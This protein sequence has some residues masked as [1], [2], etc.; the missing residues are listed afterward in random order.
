[1]KEISGYDFIKYCRDHGV[2]VSS[3]SVYPHLKALLN[4]KI[5]TFRVEGRKKI[6][7]FTEEGKVYFSREMEKDNESGIVFD[8]LK[9]AMNCDC[10]GIHKEVKMKIQDF[11]RK[12]FDLDWNN[13]EEI[14]SFID[15]LKSLENGLEE[16]I[17]VLNENC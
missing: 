4:E 12:A 8:R 16:Y 14:I 13:T 6:Y 15:Y 9:L 5:I 3:G 1:M 11:I 7:F 17:V 10:N 2:E